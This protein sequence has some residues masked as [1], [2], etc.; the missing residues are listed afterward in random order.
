MSLSLEHWEARIG[1][2]LRL[3][4]L[5]VF[6]TVV[7]WGSMAKAAHRLTVSQPAVSKSI[8]DLEHALKVRLLDRGPR[9]I[10][11]TPCGRA[12]ARRGLAVF[13]ELRQGVGEIEFLANSISGEVR[14]GCNE[15][16]SAALL[17]AVIKRLHVE[18][19]GVTVHVAQMSRP[20]SFEVRG[21]R[22][23]N[24]DLI[25]ARGEFT[26]PEEDVES[27][28]LFTEPFIVVASAHSRWTRRRQLQ[29]AELLD[30]KWILYPPEEAPGALVQQAFRNKGLALPRAHIATMSYHLRDMLL[31]S[32]DYLTVIP[33]CMLNVLNAKRRTVKPLP[34]D[35]GVQTRPVA[36]F[37]LKNRTLSPVAGLFIK[38]ARSVTR[39][40]SSLTSSGAFPVRASHQSK[41]PF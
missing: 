35:L 21:L 12:L 41:R 28:V 20:I 36:V 9:G 38:C 19:P 22:E 10:E 16:L 26:V 39:S 31:T 14:V 3:H 27:D 18:H 5:H 29:L 8:S 7:Q 13:D 23:R 15:S 40:M 32:D 17:P 11:P 24:V 4:D 37:T 34:I 30:E 33:A 6:L 2:R 25:V 1:R